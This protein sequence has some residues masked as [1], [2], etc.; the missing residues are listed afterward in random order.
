[1]VASH[2]VAGTATEAEKTESGSVAAA[3]VWM[4][5][6]VSEEALLLINPRD[7]HPLILSNDGCETL[8]H[9]LLPCGRL[10]VEVGEAAGA[11]RFGWG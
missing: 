4:M 8:L 6:A 7:Y 3:A 10:Q 9:H 1:M 2:S 11:T 5:P